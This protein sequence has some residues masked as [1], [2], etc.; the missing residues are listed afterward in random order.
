MA[1]GLM[2]IV[3]RQKCTGEGICVGIAPE[4]FA[5]DEEQIAVVMDPDAAD[6][7]TLV[8]AAQSCPQDAIRVIDIKTGE[9]L[10]A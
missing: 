4:T 10:A 3:D 1:D 2:V 5:L 6:R 7:E 8:E 9:Q